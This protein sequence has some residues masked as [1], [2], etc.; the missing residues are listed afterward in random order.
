[1]VLLAW[2]AEKLRHIG[3]ELSTEVHVC[4]IR[5]KNREHVGEKLE[6]KTERR[7]EL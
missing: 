4:N 5:A 2:L 7:G 6:E 3:D 1:M